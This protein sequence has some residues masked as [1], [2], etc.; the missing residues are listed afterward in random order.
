MKRRKKTSHCN[1]LHNARN[2]FR[3][4]IERGIKWQYA[5]DHGKEL[6]EKITH[7]HWERY[8]EFIADGIDIF[9]KNYLKYELKLE[10]PESDYSYWKVVPK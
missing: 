6:K 9:E 3:K 4:I 5:R 2:E 1:G 8:G 7:E 10:D